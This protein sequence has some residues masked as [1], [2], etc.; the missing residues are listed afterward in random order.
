MKK[1]SYAKVVATNR[2]QFAQAVVTAAVAASMVGCKTS[3]PST[4]PGSSASPGAPTTAPTTSQPGTTGTTKADCDCQTTAHQGYT[5]ITFKGFVTPEEHIPPMEIFGGGSLTIDSNH[6]L[7]TLTTGSGPFTYLEDGVSDPDD[8]YGEIE[9]VLVVSET[10]SK[11]F[12]SVAS[13]TALLPGTQLLLW[14]QDIAP[15][16]QGDDT[17]FP[18]GN[19]P[20]NDPDVRFI[21][22]R[23]ANPFRMTV[24]RKKFGAGTKSH[25]EHRPH[26]F[27]LT[28]GGSLARNFRIGQ[29]RLVDS[30]GATLVGDT[31]AENYTFFVRYGDIQP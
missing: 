12:V 23:E 18:D 31:G 5:E 6:K 19:F 11:P 7:K 21:G 9:A 30:T 17:D 10:T 25:K 14:Y 13:Y 2:R 8:R 1:E 28:D 27:K 24:K 3:E 4:Q 15:V 16:A 29:W 26:R 22:G 20:D